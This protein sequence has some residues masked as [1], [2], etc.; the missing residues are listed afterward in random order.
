MKISL[1]NN[2]STLRK[3]NNCKQDS[4]ER[5]TNLKPNQHNIMF[6][7]L[8]SRRSNYNAQTNSEKRI[9]D[10]YRTFEKLFDTRPTYDYRR[11]E[12][13]LLCNASPLQAKRARE[14]CIQHNHAGYIP[15]LYLDCGERYGSLFGQNLR[16]GDLSAVPDILR[17]IEQCN[18]S[19][20]QNFYERMLDQLYDF[21]EKYQSKDNYYTQV[22]ELYHNLETKFINAGGDENYLLNYHS[23]INHRYNVANFLR[24]ENTYYDDYFKNTANQNEV[25]NTN[26]SISEYKLP[27]PNELTTPENV[28]KVIDNPALKSSGG[29]LWNQNSNIISAIADIVPTNE[30]KDNYSKMISALK[31]LTHIDYNQKDANSISILEK[32]MNS[33]NIQFL[34]LLKNHQINYTPELDITYKNI[35]NQ[36]FKNKLKELNIRFPDI[37]NAIR[38]NSVSG[39]MAAI[40]QFKSPLMNA[41][42]KEYF[43]K[44]LSSL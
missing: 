1:I 32:I 36:N 7:G 16:S 10:F 28:L 21:I 2:Y 17:G 42:S 12:E 41:S 20:K 33:E 24:N 40:E 11:N 22:S 5:S 8:F 19:N 37:E 30:N 29:E 14:F 15:R 23:N 9:R 35:Q 6:N 34:E 25:S 31:E 44:I 43:Q 39:L 4:T 38:L 13:A 3:Q 18:D 27:S 26:S